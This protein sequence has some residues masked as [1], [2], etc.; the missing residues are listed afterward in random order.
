MFNVTMATMAPTVVTLVVA[1]VTVAQ[2]RVLF[3]HQQEVDNRLVVVDNRP[4]WQEGTIRATAPAIRVCGASGAHGEGP[5]AGWGPGHAR[6][7]QQEVVDIRPKWHFNMTPRQQAL[8]VALHQVQ[9]ARTETEV[10][11]LVHMLAAALGAS[12]TED[13]TVKALH[14]VLIQMRRPGMREKEAYS[15]TGA[16][17]SNFKKWR[18][19]VQHAQLDLPAR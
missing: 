5:T 11:V 2:Q 14:A 19:R 1:G 9:F 18:R 15:S 13:G 17:M 3:R 6:S 16:S 8:S 7:A 12:R 10:Y 4:Q